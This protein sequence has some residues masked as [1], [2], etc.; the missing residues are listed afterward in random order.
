MWYFYLIICYS[1][2]LFLLVHNCLKY[3][4]VNEL[5]VIELDWQ[6]IYINLFI[7]LFLCR[8][9][10]FKDSPQSMQDWLHPEHHSITS[11]DEAT[12]L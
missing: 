4:S 7:Y 8:N 10:K 11:R 6:C 3:K 12:L 1:N 9:G 2:M 5:L